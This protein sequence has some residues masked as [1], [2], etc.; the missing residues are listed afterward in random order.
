MLDVAWSDISHW[1]GWSH[2]A[3][4]HSVK[5]CLVIL[6]DSQVLGSCIVHR[7]FTRVAC[8]RNGLLTLRLWCL[9]V[10]VFVC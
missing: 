9:Q 4:G 6:A 3:L 8:R 10:T 5:A 2:L 7:A 1:R